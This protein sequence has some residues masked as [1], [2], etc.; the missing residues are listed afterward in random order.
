ME[1]VLTLPQK[2]RVG[3]LPMDD[4]LTVLTLFEALPEADSRT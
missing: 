3:H 4:R 2:R 1:F